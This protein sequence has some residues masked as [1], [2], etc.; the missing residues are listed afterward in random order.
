MH[1]I[2]Y[3]LLGSLVFANPGRFANAELDHLIKQ[4]GGGG[5]PVVVYGWSPHMPL[6]IRGLSELLTLGERQ[7]I[8]IVPV[9]D[10]IANE[11]LVTQVMSHQHWPIAYAT[12]AKSAHLI[13]LGFRVHY[14]SY[15]LISH[16][17]VASGLLPGYKTPNNLKAYFRKYL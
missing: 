8:K 12:R 14:P 3:A 15:L 1:F 10:P 16:G 5:Q 11:T 4:T 6:S 7:D 17:R 13:A 2:L 9:L